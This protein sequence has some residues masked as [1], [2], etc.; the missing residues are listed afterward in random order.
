[1]NIKSTYNL[2]KNAILFGG[3]AI[4][5]FCLLQQCNSN[6][7]LKREIV[8]VQQVSDRNLNNYK[9]T[10]D[11][12]IIEKNKNEELVSSIRSFEYDVNTLTDNNKKLINK[13][14]IQ[15]NINSNLEDVN[16]L[17]STSINIKDSIINATGTVTVVEDTILVN[18]KDEYT[19]DEYNWRMFDGQISLLKDSTKY[20]LSSSR[21]DITQGI[22]L[23][24]AIINDEGFERLKITTP[25]DGVTFTNIENIN[26]V[27]DRL[28]NKYKKKAGW[29][30]GIGF[31][32]GINLNNNQ[33]IS[34]GP[35][36]G[37]GI[38]W[39]PSFLKF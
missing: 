27:N 20:S 29:S 11:T 14:S 2:Y 37:I 19:F 6:Q 25:Y 7:N 18:I 12:I 34:T 28:N 26:L 9:A 22:G 39:S 17:L 31:Q 8:Q 13:Y 10:Q 24:A 36:I 5:V 23:S 16:N 15:L 4:L 33:V 21:F 3:L 30:I 38:Y 35:A 1:M 32:Y